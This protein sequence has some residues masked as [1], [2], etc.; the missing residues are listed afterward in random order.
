MF[1]YL[2]DNRWMEGNV[3]KSY[4]VVPGPMGF[5]V[6]KGNSSRAFAGFEDIINRETTGGWIYHS[7]E[8]ISVT[9]KSGCK[10]SPN[11]ERTNYYMLIFERD[12]EGGKQIEESV[13][14]EKPVL[15]TKTQK[16]SIDTTEKADSP[17]GLVCPSCGAPQKENAKFCTKCGHK[18]G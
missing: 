2:G 7:M 10:L 5:T 6:D 3:M 13:V 14:V 9:E 15:N 12:S 16:A 8:T 4:K 1:V 11:F 17:S 18:L